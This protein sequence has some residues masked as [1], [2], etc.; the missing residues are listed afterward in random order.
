MIDFASRSSRHL[1]FEFSTLP[2]S[3]LYQYIM[4]YDLVPVI[5]PTPL[6]AED[7]PP[8]IALLDS[9]RMASRAPTPA[10]LIPVS[11]PAN[12]PRRSRETKEASR[13][14]ST[15]L[16]EEELRGGMEQV[17]VLADIAELHNVLATIAQR[18]FRESSIREVDTLASFMGAVKTRR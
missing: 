14:R 8:P 1:Q 9:A 4:Q 12:R 7:P 13:R 11:T 2:T 5:Y 6:T 3:A 18:H 10:P 17:P 15:R 16:L